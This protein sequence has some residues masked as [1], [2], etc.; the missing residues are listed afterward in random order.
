MSPC[1]VIAF[2][3]AILARYQ[4][5][6]RLRLDCDG[7]IVI[8]RLSKYHLR[9]TLLRSIHSISS[10]DHRRAIKPLLKPTEGLAVCQS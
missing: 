2:I 10:L 5:F 4:L 8:T 6:N 3:Q 1:V 7:L 9:S